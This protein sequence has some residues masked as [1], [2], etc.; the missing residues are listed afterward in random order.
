MFEGILYF[1]TLE[2]CSPQVGIGDIITLGGG[3][4]GGGIHDVS[5]A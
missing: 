1:L 5:C 3:G 4:G 2:H